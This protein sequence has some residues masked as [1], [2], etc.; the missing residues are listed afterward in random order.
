MS[1][2]GA[3]TE[4][5]SKLEED[6]LIEMLE[7]VVKNESDKAQAAM[8]ACLRG[9]DIVGERYENGEYF[10]SDLIYAGELMTRAAGILK[11][12][13]VTPEPGYGRDISVMLCT[14]KGDLHDVGKNIVH[15][16][17]EESGFFVVD[18]GVDVSPETIVEKIKQ[19]KIK[20]LLL[21]GVLTGSV[22]SMKHTV[23]ALADAGLRKNLHILVG[24]MPV[25][26]ENCRLI[27]ADAWTRSPR[28]TV[29]YCR[30]WAV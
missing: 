5:I 20:I 8:D 16:M 3:V 25:N 7:A 4:A 11:K 12:V 30:E 29:R 27:G 17:L 23:E 6:A 28:A 1:D 9:L 2:F 10:V 21:S 26:E 13:L 14:V 19:T 24:G 15:A 18:L 22:S